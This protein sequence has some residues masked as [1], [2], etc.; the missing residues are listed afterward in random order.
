MEVL[1]LKSKSSAIFATLSF[2]NPLAKIQADEAFK[3]D[4]AAWQPKAV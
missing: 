3:D 1:S 2:K 4:E